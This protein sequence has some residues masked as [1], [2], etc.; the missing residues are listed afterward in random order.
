MQRCT[1]SHRTESQGSSTYTSG[2][3]G[4]ILAI[5]A[6]GVSP[7]DRAAN[8]CQDALLSQTKDAFPTSRLR[9]LRAAGRDVFRLRQRLNR[10][11]EIS[12]RRSVDV[13]P[14]TASAANIR[15]ATTPIA[16]HQTRTPIRRK[17]A[18]RARLV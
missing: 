8:V 12:F 9:G 10:S 17:R 4:F 7:R 14:E 1:S 11:Y 2:D 13:D 16:S 18:D 3:L 5:L 15:L 6:L